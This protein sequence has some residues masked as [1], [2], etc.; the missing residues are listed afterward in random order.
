MR[1]VWMVLLLLAACP[2]PADDDTSP[3]PDDDSGA[4]VDDDSTDPPDDDTGDDDSGVGCLIES[5]APSAC[6]GGN[7]AIATPLTG[8]FVSFGDGCHDFQTL[9][10]ALH[11]VCFEGDTSAMPDLSALGQVGLRFLGSCD[12]KGGPSATMT[13]FEWYDPSR[14]L[15][16]VSA[17]MEG[18]WADWEVSAPSAISGCEVPCMCWEDC[19]Q[20][21][22]I[23]TDGAVEL[24]ATPGVTE[25]GGGFS[26]TMW[27][28]WTG[29]GEP[30][31]ID[32]PGSEVQ[33]WMLAADDAFQARPVPRLIVPA[34]FPPGPLWDD[35]IAGAPQVGRIIAN[36]DSGPGDT[37]DPALVSAIAGAQAAGIEVLGYVHTVYAG[38]DELE[39][40]A[41][42]DRW[43]SF[44]GVDGIFFDEVSGLDDCVAQEGW[45]EAR[46]DYSRTLV[47]GAVVVMNP[48]TDT[49]PSY[50]GF[51]DTLVLF[52]GLTQAHAAFVPEDA[53]LGLLSDEV[54]HLLHGATPS[55][56]APAFTRARS[57]GV[58]WFYVTD[59]DLPN[60]WDVLPTFWDD[61]LALAGP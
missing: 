58:G 60:P 46:V 10:A 3:T 40:D 16:M 21:E 15:L 42:T 52:E 30:E 51:A 28:G 11:E 18:N 5:P 50:A 12:P 23:A 55:G 2:D 17:Q 38:R 4:L 19:R 9:D 8:T 34:Y 48:G 22:V 6:A 45:Y 27:T 54:G 1:L 32:G 20:K 7:I 14:V 31:C 49:C 53:S 36:P 37:V 13:V 29:L 47:P 26:L 43:F 41:E 59:D 25:V 56:L 39:V 61:E 33:R 57:W 44:Y 24:R 35:L